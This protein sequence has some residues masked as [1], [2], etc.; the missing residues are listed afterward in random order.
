MSS[1]T[2]APEMIEQNGQKLALVS[3]IK[4]VEANREFQNNVNVVQNQRNIAVDLK[5]RIDQA[6]TPAERQALQQK[7][8]ETLKSLDS[9]NALMAKT[10]GFSLLRNYVI[11]FIKTRLY[12]PLSDEEFAKM[13]PEDKIKPDA[14]KTIDGKVYAYIATITTAA[15]NDIFRQNVQLV[16]TQRQ[17]LVQLKQALDKATGDED[18]KKLDEEFKKSE[19]VLVNNNNEMVKRYGFSLMRNYLM[20]VEEAKLYTALTEEEIKKTSGETEAKPK[21]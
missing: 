6:M 18:K 8:D 16:Q 9:N 19:E 3:T 4:T 12:T 15:E 10:Y 5:K 13:S 11:S 21:E 7:L 14:I 1:E 20:E 17:R 2:D